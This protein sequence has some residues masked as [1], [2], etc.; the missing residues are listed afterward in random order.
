MTF[1]D[2]LKNDL[3]VERYS[4]S[5]FAS[6]AQV[7]VTY[8][9]RILACQ[10]VPSIHIASVVPSIHIASS[11]AVAASRCTGKTYTPDMFTTVARH[12]RLARAEAEL[13]ELRSK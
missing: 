2:K 12:D 5:A 10:V 3:K 4:L 8:L 6:E 13:D 1:K 7:S 9:Y 11:L